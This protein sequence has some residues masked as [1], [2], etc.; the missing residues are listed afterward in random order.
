MIPLP[1]GQSDTI[2]ELIP[3]AYPAHHTEILLRT[4]SLQPQHPPRNPNPHFLVL[5]RRPTP[6]P[7]VR[8]KLSQVPRMVGCG[9]EVSDSIR[10]REGGGHDG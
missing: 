5:P 8:A 6:P 3:H 4:P 2:Q 9:G 1:N 7:P 10:E